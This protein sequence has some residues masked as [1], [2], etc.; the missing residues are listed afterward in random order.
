M[1]LRRLVDEGF[2][3][4]DAALLNQAVLVLFGVVGV[5]ALATYARFYLV[6][7][8]GERV[9]ADIRQQVFNHI[10]TL[11]PAYYELTRTGEVLRSAERRVGKEGVSTCSSR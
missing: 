9:V 11:S 5:L 6:S 10:L 4:S 1:G 2:A 8:L 7:W 3:G